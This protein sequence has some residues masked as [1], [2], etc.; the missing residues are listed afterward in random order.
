MKVPRADTDVT[1]ATRN[2]EGIFHA[3]THTA[4]IIC[5]THT[6]TYIHIDAYT[7]THTQDHTH[8]HT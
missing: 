3:V 5:N 4:E 7:L 6:H 8:T 1:D 2:S